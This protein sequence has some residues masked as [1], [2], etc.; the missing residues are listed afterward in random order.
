MNRLIHTSIDE[1]AGLCSTTIELDVGVLG[2]RPAIVTYRL[3]FPLPDSPS[4]TV[5]RCTMADDRGERLH[6][7]MPV[8]ALQSLAFR[9][10]DDLLEH[11]VFHD[12]PDLDEV[13]EDM[14]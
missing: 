8:L 6:I 5:L 12:Y 2:V 7:A 14:G 1:A 9:I 3:R 4:V 13:M 11:G 10:E